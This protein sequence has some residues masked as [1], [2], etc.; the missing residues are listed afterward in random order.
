MRQVWSVDVPVEA[1]AALSVASAGWAASTMTVVAIG[2][3]RLGEFVER[4]GETEPLAERVDPESIVTAA[5][6]LH[7]RMPADLDG[8]VLG[9]LRPLTGLSRP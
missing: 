5:K 1:V 9:G 8:D 6:V 2:L 4:S 7:E 3:D